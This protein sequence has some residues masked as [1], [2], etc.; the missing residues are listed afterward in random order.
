[1]TATRFYSRALVATKA[2]PLHKGH[3]YL[4]REALRLSEAVTVFVVWRQGESPDGAL[5]AEWVR[6][7]FP[8]VDVRL[9][10]DLNTDDDDPESSYL[11]S[12]Y[13]L[14]IMRGEPFD[15]VFSSE[16]YGRR[17]A[18]EMGVAHV[19]VDEHRT[20]VPISGTAIRNDPYAHWQYINDEA[21]RHYLKRVLVVGAES[22]GKSTL[23]KNL[24]AKY[25]TVFSPEYG[26]IYVERLGDSSEATTPEH[27]HII[28]AD[29]VNNQ[30]ILDA[31][32][33]K[34]ARIVCFYDTCL[35]STGIWY[36]LW[37]PNRIGDPLHMTIIDAAIKNDKYD[38]VLLSDNSGADMFDDGY[39]EMSDSER[40]WMT[41][42]LKEQYPRA[43]LLTGTWAERTTAAIKAVNELFEGSEVTLP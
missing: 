1:M 9:V 5:R 28:F 38:L 16:A 21:K 6:K 15:V 34:D 31:E 40:N 3:E 19:T 42:Q 39:R 36:E 26:R 11:W 17:W 7:T 4:I 43:V 12:V 10:A 25:G 37:Q 27:E 30:P 41:A 18:N 22:T 32:V 33:E 2:Y 29:I 14:Q 24:A 8:T 35:F 23:C 13:T 20:R